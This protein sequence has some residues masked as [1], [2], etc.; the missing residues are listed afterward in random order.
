MGGK[1]TMNRTLYF[2]KVSL[3]SQEV[4]DLVDNYDFRYK[5]TNDI[6]YMLK[7]N[8]ELVVPYSYTDEDGEAHSGEIK[9][10]LSI[11]EKTDSDIHGFLDRTTLLFVKQRDEEGILKTHAVNDTEAVEFFYDVL[12]EYIAYDT[13][14]RFGK[15]MFNDAFGLMMNHCSEQEGFSYS[16]YLGSYNKGMSIDEIQE[17][18]KKDKH[19]KELIITYRPANPDEKMIEKVRKAS[20]SERIKDSKAA[21]RSIIYKAKGRDCIDGSASIIQDDLQTLV[22][23]NKGI[24]IKE[25][26]QFSYAEVK[27]VN[28]S[29]DVKSTADAKPFTRKFKDDINEFIAE[30]KRGISQILGR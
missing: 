29:G 21:E 17:A 20:E 18:I 26:T 4:Y 19:I 27:S 5:L 14:Q 12:H 7:H 11:Q 8:S 6:I 30:A 9:Y 16:F 15:N 10:T 22:E 25:M 24:D 2:S 23:L 13:R 28:E 1:G 3:D